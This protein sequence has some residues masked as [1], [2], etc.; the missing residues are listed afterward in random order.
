MEGQRALYSPDP[1]QCDM[2]QKLKINLKS[3]I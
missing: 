1:A 3:K 2:I